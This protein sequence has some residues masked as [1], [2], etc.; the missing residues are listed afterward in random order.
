MWQSQVKKLL[1]AKRQVLC[2][3]SNH[4]EGFLCWLHALSA[5]IFKPIFSLSLNFF[6]KSLLV[7]YYWPGM[8]FEAWIELLP[9]L[10]IAIWCRNQNHCVELSGNLADQFCDSSIDFPHPWLGMASEACLCFPPLRWLLRLAWW[11]CYWNRDNSLSLN[12]PYWSARNKSFVNGC[13][14]S[15]ARNLCLPIMI[16]NDLSC[17]SA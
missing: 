9:T 15:A 10:L 8:L 2:S 5:L 4:R 11:P 7:R 17:L 12:R 16:T 1:T 14:I 6:W 3:S 13:T